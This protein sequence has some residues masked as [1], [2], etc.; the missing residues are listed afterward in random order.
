MFVRPACVHG[1]CICLHVFA[2]HIAHLHVVARLFLTHM[3][4]TKYVRKIHLLLFACMSICVYTHHIARLHVVARLFLTHMQSTVQSTRGRLVCFHSHAVWLFCQVVAQRKSVLLCVYHTWGAC[5][6]VHVY[7]CLC[8][9]VCIYVYMYACVY[10]YVCV[11]IYIYIFMC[12]RNTV[13]EH[14]WTP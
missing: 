6:Y 14:V 12:V 1:S 3:H 4:S 2:H 13:L 7:L 10:I 5:V 11:Y 9:Y 8:V